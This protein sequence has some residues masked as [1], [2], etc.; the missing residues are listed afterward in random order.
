MSY[1]DE[2]DEIL[3][4]LQFRVEMGRTAT[5]L[6]LM[7]AIEDNM[8]NEELVEHY[9]EQ[10]GRMEHAHNVSNFKQALDSIKSLRPE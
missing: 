5:Q 8:G 7:Q 6:H 10:T 1:Q 4:K 3:G 2:V 9:T